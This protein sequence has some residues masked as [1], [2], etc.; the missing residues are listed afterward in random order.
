MDTR[1]PHLGEEGFRLL[2]FNHPEPMWVY[3][4]ETLAFLEVN[5]AAVRQYGYTR[6]AFLAMSIREVHPAADV[7]RL[8]EHLASGTAG[9]GEAG[10]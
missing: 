6:E 7:P 5:E 2:F 10:T 8:L 9:L 4:L 1:T 3:D